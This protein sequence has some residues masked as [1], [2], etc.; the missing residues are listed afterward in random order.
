[1]KTLKRTVLVVAVISFLTQASFAQSGATMKTQSPVKSQTT[2]TSKAV[3]ATGQTKTSV[4]GQN[5]AIA[6][7]THCPNYIDKNKDNV[8]DNPSCHK[9][10]RC[11]LSNSKSQ[12]VKENDSG[13]NKQQPKK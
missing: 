3:K 8:C 5:D 7:P 13:K 9:K 11:T 2:Q 4:A 1:M 6:K 10:T 12:P